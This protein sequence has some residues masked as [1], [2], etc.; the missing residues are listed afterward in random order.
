M[1]YSEEEKRMRAFYNSL[2]EKDR[3]HYAALEAA[4]IGYGGITYILNSGSFL[5]PTLVLFE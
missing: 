2:S 1:E 3:R 5:P 4:R